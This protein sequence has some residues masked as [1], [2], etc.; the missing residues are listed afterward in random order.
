M[1]CGAVSIYLFYLVGI[2][3]FI[4]VNRNALFSV[5]CN[6]N[7]VRTLETSGITTTDVPYFDNKLRGLN[8]SSLE[9]NK[10]SKQLTDLFK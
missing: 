6:C 7:S 3:L 8:N 5:P 10:E 9:Y 2:S 4:F 1:R